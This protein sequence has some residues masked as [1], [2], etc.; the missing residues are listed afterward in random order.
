MRHM[1]KL[2][3]RHSNILCFFCQTPVSPFPKN[4][5]NFKCPTCSCWNRYDVNG[6]ILSD[7]PAMHDETLNKNSFAKRGMYEILMG[8]D[9]LQILRVWFRI[10]SPRI[11]RFPTSYGPGPFCHTCQ[12]NQMLIV[13]LLSSYLPPP[14]VR[15]LSSSKSPRTAN[16]YTPYHRAPDTLSALK[17]SRNTANHYTCDTHRSVRTVC[18]WLRMRFGR[19]I[20][21]PARRLSGLG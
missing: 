9:T 20:R 13:N 8:E 19:R 1:S 16:S 7:E 14:E 11:D 2:F 4:P 12:T 6:E 3:R 15:P 5:R 18:P 17:C 10:A 21:W